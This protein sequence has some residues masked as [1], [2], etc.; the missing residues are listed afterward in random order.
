[1]RSLSRSL[2]RSLIQ[3]DLRGSGVAEGDILGISIR[4]AVDLALGRITPPPSSN[5]KSRL[6]CHE[7]G[8][9]SQIRSCLYR[10]QGPSEENSGSHRR[11]QIEATILPLCVPLIQAVGH[12]MAYDAAI[13]ASVDPTLIGIYL[14]S[15]ILSDPAWY[16]EAND[17]SIRLSRSE[18]LEM[19]LAVCTK[20]VARLEEWLD[21]LEI[22]PYVLASIVSEEKWDA[23]EQTLEIFGGPLDSKMELSGIDIDTA[24]QGSQSIT[25]LPRSSQSSF[26]AAKL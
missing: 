21:K 11:R 13:E 17:P 4:F 8:V 18:Q 23:Y 6:A 15:A 3:S 14:S 24:I 19:Q 2:T 1:M 25:Y 9:V 22:E 7:A 10:N 5:P 16:S 26:V 12:R 20:G